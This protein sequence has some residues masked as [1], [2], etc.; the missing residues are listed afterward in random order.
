MRFDSVA[1]GIL[2]R[3]VLAWMR[4]KFGTKPLPI[5]KLAGPV[6]IWA[7]VDTDRE[8]TDYLRNT[9]A[10]WLRPDRGNFD[11]PCWMIDGEYVPTHKPLYDD[12]QNACNFR[13]FSTHY[14][15]N[16]SAMHAQM[17]SLQHALQQQSQNTGYYSQSRQ[18]QLSSYMGNFGTVIKY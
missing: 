17:Q 10:F 9:T 16:Y 5:P 13:D 4:L 8:E 11:V 18:N 3:K 1:W 12:A 15:Q 14:G 7:S 2:K 6:R